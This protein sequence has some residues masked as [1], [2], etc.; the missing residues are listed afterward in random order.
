MQRSTIAVVF[1]I[2]NLVFASW[3]VLGTL[4]A[5]LM[6][7]MADDPK[8]RNPV[9]QLM[10][11]NPGYALFNQV[12][13]GLGLFAAIALAVAGI[14]LLQM[15]PWGRLLSIGYALFGIVMTLVQVVAGYFFLLA[16]MMQRAANMP[17]GPEKAG[18]IIGTVGGT[19]GGCFGFI[20]PV[21]LLFFMFRPSLVAALQRPPTAEPFDFPPPGPQ[22][23]RP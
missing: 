18:L 10:R 5:V 1:G 19:C 21:I 11:E 9:L 6:F 22:A 16:P 20:Y 4:I 8:M 14:G 2:L 12:A 15:K 3:G 13:I 17:P 7:Q 23:Y